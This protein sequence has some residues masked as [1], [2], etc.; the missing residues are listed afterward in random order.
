MLVLFSDWY[1]EYIA[2]ESNYRAV[3]ILQQWKLP[4]LYVC[5]KINPVIHLHWFLL[6][7]SANKAAAGACLLCK[8]S[9]V[10][11]RTCWPGKVCWTEPSGRL[12]T[13]D[14]EGE[15]ALCGSLQCSLCELIKKNCFV[16]ISNAK[17]L[18]TNWRSYSA[19]TSLPVCQGY[20]KCNRCRR[21]PFTNR[22]GRE[23]CE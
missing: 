9:E 17:K 18:V 7:C 20:L 8:R 15:R 16:L 13:L 10:S 22:R 4:S 3:V 11:T 21:W 12:S 23:E 14:S 2:A 5:L 6:H 19:T 1:D